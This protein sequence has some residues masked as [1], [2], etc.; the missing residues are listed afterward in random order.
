[1]ADEDGDGYKI[2]L[3]QQIFGKAAAIPGHKPPEPKANDV[4]EAQV[5]GIAAR[6]SAVRESPPPAATNLETIEGKAQ[7]KQLKTAA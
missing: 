3:A 7:P 6:D 5:A 1:V 2:T 4:R